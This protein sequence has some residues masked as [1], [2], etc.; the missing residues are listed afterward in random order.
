MNRCV[1]LFLVLISAAR[2]ATAGGA[3]SAAVFEG[4]VLCLRVPQLTGDFT[5]QFRQ[6]Q[7]TNKIAGTILDLRFA[8]GDTA[9]VEAAVKIFSAQKKPLVILVNGQMRGGAV[10]LALHL[11]ADKLGVIIGSTNLTGKI[12]PDIAVAVSVEDERQ[13]L[14]NPFAAT[15]TNGVVTN[16]N[17]ILSFVDHMTEAEL[18]RKRIKDGEDPG[19]DED[20][21]PR[22]APPSPVI[23]D[24]VLARAVDLVKALAVL[25]PSHD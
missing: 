8:E 17:E 13:F 15:T 14:A 9:A 2:V 25:K 16:K 22:P 6:L 3:P 24:P 7:P 1:I 4:K 12:T 21:T 10:E 18:V 20:L 5:G 11:R 23:L 19:D